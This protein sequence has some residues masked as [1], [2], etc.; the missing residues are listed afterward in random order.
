MIDGIQQ[1]SGSALHSIV[2]HNPDALKEFQEAHS[3]P[4][5]ATD[6]A[7]T[8]ANPKIDAVYIGMPN[9]EHHMDDNP[10]IFGRQSGVAA[11]S[12][13]FEDGVL[14]S[15]QSTDSY[16]TNFAFSFWDSEGELRFVTNPWQPVAGRGHLQM[17]PYEGQIEDIYVG[18]EFDSF[19]HQIKMVA[20]HVKAE[21]LEADCPSPRLNNRLQVMAFLPSKCWRTS[22]A[23]TSKTDRPSKST[24]G[25]SCTPKT[26]AVAANGS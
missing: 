7:A 10:G 5:I 24:S 18:D 8:L 2:G 4:L 9:H 15:L 23:Q 13:C 19:Y 3:F 12:A 25:P 22:P 26:S 16:G 17:C 6:V 21:Q 1:S 14:P 20:R 11:V